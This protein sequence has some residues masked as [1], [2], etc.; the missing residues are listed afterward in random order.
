[1]VFVSRIL[2]KYLGWDIQKLAARIVMCKALSNKGLHTFHGLIGYC[3]KDAQQDHF[4]T[5]DHNVTA[6]DIN[7]GLEQLAL[8]GQ[9]E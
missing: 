9:E 8:H 3:M 1:M 7:I 2:K 5:I 6:E 4:Q